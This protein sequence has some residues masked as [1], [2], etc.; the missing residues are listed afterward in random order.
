MAVP[1]RGRGAVATFALAAIVLLFTALTYSSLEA[2]PPHSATLALALQEVSDDAYLVVD[3]PVEEAGHAG[4]AD[5]AAAADPVPP[6]PP[7]RRETPRP[8]P[9]PL[10]RIWPRRCTS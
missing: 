8:R 4:H 5:Q 9:H 1:V 7:P 10:A 2:R 6:P 3:V